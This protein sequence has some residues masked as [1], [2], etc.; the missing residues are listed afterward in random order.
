MGGGGVEGGW[1]VFVKIRDSLK[2]INFSVA[3]YL[4]HPICRFG[5]GWVFFFWIGVG[6]FM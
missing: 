4:A 5:F 3:E 6:L 2:R 1:V